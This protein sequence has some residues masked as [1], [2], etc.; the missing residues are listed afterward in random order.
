MDL[1][2]DLPPASWGG[3]AR[4]HA[5]VLTGVQKKKAEGTA[6]LAQP[7]L[8]FI[9][10]SAMLKVQVHCCQ[11]YTPKVQIHCKSTAASVWWLQAH[12][13][14]CDATGANSLLPVLYSKA[15]CKFTANS[16]LP[17]YGG[18]EFT[19]ACWL[20]AHC[21]QFHAA[22]AKPVLCCRALMPHIQ[23]AASV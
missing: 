9:A 20:Q 1:Q 2:P 6:H 14:Q 21:R 16:L 17:D 11:C 7:H 8:K 3:M 22:S 15:K 12:C 18:C 19:A 5:V 13:C 23:P 4:H 10:S